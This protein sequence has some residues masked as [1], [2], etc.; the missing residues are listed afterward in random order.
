[1]HKNPLSIALILSLVMAAEVI[2]YM[3]LMRESLPEVISIS[4][5]NQ[6]AA[7]GAISSELIPADRLADWTP[8]VTVGVPGGIPNRTN[9]IDVTAAPYFADNTGAVDSGSII[10]QAVMDAPAESVIYLPEGTYKFE[11]S[12]LSIYANSRKSNVTIRGAGMD[13]TIIDCRTGSSCIFIGTGSDWNWPY[14]STGNKVVSGKS[15][16]STQLTVEDGAPYTV[17]S[18]LLLNGGQDKNLPVMSVGGFEHVQKQFVRITGKSGNTLTFFP[19][20]AMDL[21][22]VEV[23]ARVAQQQVEYVGVEDLTVDT[24]GGNGFKYGIWAEQTYGFWMRNVKVQ[25]SSN[26]NVF[27]M[28]SLGCEVRHS[29][30]GPLFKSESPN[31]AGLLLNIITGCLIEDNIITDSFPNIEL[32]HGSS[33]NVFAYNFLNNKSGLIGIDTNHGPHNSFNLYE[34]NI[35]HNLMADGYFGSVSHDTI[36]RNWFTGL[37]LPSTQTYCFSLKRFTR[38]YSLVGNMLG[39]SGNKTVCEGYGQPYIGNGSSYGTAQPSVGDWW[40]DWN[41][42]DGPSVRGTVTAIYDVS[43]TWNGVNCVKCGADITLSSGSLSQEAIPNF[44]TSDGGGFSGIVISADG[45]SYKLDRSPWSQSIDVPVG[46][47]FVAWPGASGFGE[48][49]LD[50][51]AS[52]IF[53]G[54]W[55]AATDSIPPSESLGSQVL[56]ASLYLPSKPAWFGDLTWPPIDSSNPREDITAIP[57]GYRYKNGVEA[58]GADN[59]NP[60]PP[61]PSTSAN[62]SVLKS[63]SGSGSVSGGTISCGSK[64]TVALS[65]GS[66]ITLTATPDSGSTF[67]GWSGACTGTETCTITVSANTFVTATFTASVSAGPDTTRP[68]I[69]VTS[70]VSGTTLKGSVSLSATAS[71]DVGVLGVQFKLDGVNLGEE[72]S[73][74]PY[75]GSWNTLGVS[76]GSHIL[77]A[78]ARDAAGN[79]SIS[80]SVSVIVANTTTS[81][82][83]GGGGGGTGGGGSTS[84]TTPPS[85][86]GGLSLSVISETQINLSW[87]ASTDS[88][89]VSGYY[90]YRNGAQVASVSAPSYASLNL[91]PNTLYSFTVAAY[92]AAGNVSRQSASVSAKTKSVTTTT[93]TNPSTLVSA[94]PR[95]TLLR[96][97]TPAAGTPVTLSWSAPSSL[98]SKV[99]IARR[100]SSYLLVPDALFTVATLP[101]TATSWTD[102]TAVLGK[103]YFYSVFSQNASGKYSDP[104]VI[105]FTPSRITT[106]TQKT[107]TLTPTVL[108]KRLAAPL[109][110]VASSLNRTLS[111]GSSGEDVRTLQ[112]I[113]NTK[114]FPIAVTGVG[115]KGRE[116]T[117]FGPA[118]KTALQK[119]QCAK[120]LICS[121][122]P[123]TN[124]FG[125]AGTR[126]RAELMKK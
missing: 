109:P 21:S 18:L 8:W 48:L 106:A 67:A 114:G 49:D 3:G 76:D 23:I 7:V 101:K 58:P 81:S 60:P 43:A 85:T 25:H 68:S 27:I 116:T 12:S 31:G 103:T 35:G 126:T 71:D 87:T 86:P 110:I 93:T 118:T 47:T 55:R 45:N 6:M 37:G 14:P 123:S 40:A 108:Q 115:S 107:G 42:T 13:K 24:F 38:N 90:V 34:G 56:P 102:T 57:A 64:C 26:Y 17:G 95:V 121:G 96:A 119:F 51:E 5:S 36:Y 84:D 50:V 88:S 91:T 117:L 74:A 113:L 52:T 75:S 105:A 39:N 1:M 20:L 72:L 80:N 94:V 66:S 104:S 32:N 15:K 78:I 29:Y 30:M 9:I 19:P 44:T 112:R 28:D 22:G 100:T 83:G 120:L 97:S 10:V 59:N 89:G 92:D 33:G 124:G 77:T 73:T 69:S 2:V 122:S 11:T 70:P 61:P 99:V 82:G 54:N 41:P 62:L 111:L 63:G 79:S 125:A 98:V 4:L 46:S 16:G 53:K 65:P